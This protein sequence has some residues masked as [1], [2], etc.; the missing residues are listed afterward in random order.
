MCDKK[1]V[2][3][4]HPWGETVTKVEIPHEVIG[5]DIIEHGERVYVRKTH[6]VYHEATRLIIRD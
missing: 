1:I 6:D 5:P 2:S 3:L 4:R